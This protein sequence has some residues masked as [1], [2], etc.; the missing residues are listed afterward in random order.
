MIAH[1]SLVNG[2]LNMHFLNIIFFR[3]QVIEK[4]LELRGMLS[5]LRSSLHIHTSTLLFQI[6][7]ETKAYIAK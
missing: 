5:P 3:C 4:A 2:T 6:N 7:T 1:N